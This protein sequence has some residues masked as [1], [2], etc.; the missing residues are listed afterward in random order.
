MFQKI[1]LSILSAFLLFIS[2]PPFSQFTFLIFLAFVPL[3]IIESHLHK[4]H[5]TLK[6]YYI[7]VYLAFFLFNL[8]TTF[9]VKNAHFGGAV[10]AILCNSFFMA[11]IFSLYVKVQSL[12]KW[13]YT[14]F[15]LPI[16]WI[17]FEYLHLNWDLSWPWLTLG[18]VFSS[19][20]NWVQWYSVTGVLGGTLWIFIVNRY[21][22]RIYQ[23]RKKRYIAFLLLALIVPLIISKKIHDTAS[24]MRAHQHMNVLVVQPNINPYYEKF[25]MS[26]ESQTKLLLDLATPKINHELDFL[27][28]P[29]TF[30]V[31]AI[32]QHKFDTNAH[33][34]KFN[35]LITQFPNLNIIVGAVTFQLSEKGPRAKPSSSYPDQWYKVYNSALHIKNNNIQVYNKS[36]LVPGAEQMPFQRF[37]YPIFGDQI[38]Q[39]GNSTALGNFAIQDTVSVFSSYSGMKIAP[40]I[41]YES[42]YGDYV[43]KFIQKGAD[44]IFIITNDGWWKKTSGYKQHNMYAQLRAIETRRY[45]ARS[46][47][48]GISSIIN[49][50]GEIQESILWDKKDVISYQLPVYDRKTFYVEYGDFLGRFCGFFSALILLSSFVMNKLKI[51]TK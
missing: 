9:W 41:C 10:F 14:F 40:I 32:W 34:K 15:I 42:I 19:H 12:V 47:N 16:F 27:I 18:N 33:I 51:K 17:G 7:Y 8:C 49:H 30:L 28:L 21:F 1:T 11:T 31:S 44:A 38:L 23:S 36:K 4:K 2:W 3:F 50:L 48:T 6:S 24:E 22:F 37:F 39:I 5:I 46:A 13:K 43:R 35:P 26:Q 29:E 45:I 20:P 25:S